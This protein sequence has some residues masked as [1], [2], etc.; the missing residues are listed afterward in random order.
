[1]S[2]LL[3]CQF[4]LHILYSATYDCFVCVSLSLSSTD[5]LSQRAAGKEEKENG[6]NFLCQTL[7]TKTELWTHQRTSRHR[8]A[9]RSMLHISWL[10]LQWPSNAPAYSNNQTCISGQKWV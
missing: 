5:P 1:M 10:S 7:L 9:G 8:R 6:R 2:D 4:V 3:G